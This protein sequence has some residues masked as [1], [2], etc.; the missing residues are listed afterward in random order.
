[1]AAANIALNVTAGGL[2]Q[3]IQNQV[4]NAQQT[5]NRRPLRLKLDPKGFTQPLGKISGD[6]SEFQKSLDASVARTFAFGAA[7]GVVN[8][9]SDAF[10]ALAQ[11]TIEVQKELKNINVLLGLSVSNLSTFSNELFGVA[12]NTAQTFKT[13]ATAATE[14]SRQGLSAEE[15]LKRVNDAM[16]LTRLSGL[17]AEQAVASLTAAV[18]GF[19][20]EAISTT[21]V[22]NRLA[23]V[24]AAFAVS[25][26][27]LADA[28]ARAGS[29]AQGAKV[30]FNELLAMVTSV[31][32]QTAR[33][34][35]VIGNA[36]K[37]IF[38][39]IQRSGVQDA[40]EE[41]GVATRNVD[42]SF[43]SGITVLK[44]YARTYDTLTDA[45]KAYTAE[46][47]AGVF[48]INNLKALVN[49]LNS[50]F[51][52]YDRALKVAN[53]STNEAN[54]RN[55]EL[56]KT[57]A[58]LIAQT[59][60]SMQQLGAALGNL[61]GAEIF[62]RLIKGVQAFADFFNKVL[63]PEEGNQFAIKFVKAIGSFI[64]GPGLIIIGGA[65]IKL[66]AFISK[67]AGAAV[68]SIFT[69]NT[70]TQRQQQ[71]Q[72]AILATI[73][74]EE[75]VYK[76]ILANAGNTA[77]QE[78]I[79]LDTLRQQTAQRAMQ[80]K[81][82][83]Q[84]ASSAAFKGVA[85]KGGTITPMGGRR[86]AGARAA[87][88]A[89]GHVPNFAVAAANT[90]EFL[91][92]NFAATQ[93]AK[94]IKAG[95]GGASPGARV[96]KVA[97]NPQKDAILNPD[98]VAAMG[99]PSGAQQIGAAG[100]FV[101]NFGRLRMQVPP[102]GRGGGGRQGAGFQQFKLA[103]TLNL[104]AF[105]GQSPIKFD[106]NQRPYI[107]QTRGGALDIFKRDN[108]RI[109]LEQ[110]SF[111]KDMYY[112]QGGSLT[113]ELKERIKNLYYSTSKMQT[114]GL[115]SRPMERNYERAQ[116]GR[117]AG[118]FVP[119]FAPRKKP[120][121]PITLVG[122]SAGAVV[123]PRAG[124]RG[125]LNM[126]IPGNTIL[127][128]KVKF[129]N[130]SALLK[131]P[132][133]GDGNLLAA[134][135]QTSSAKG[136]LKSYLA[137]TTKNFFKK[138]SG[139]KG[140]PEFNLSDNYPDAGKV[141][142][143]FLATGAKGYIFEEIIR[144]IQGDIKQVGAVKENAAFDINPRAL[145][146][147][148]LKDLFNLPSSTR[149]IELKSG[150]DIRKI[151]GKYKQD[152]IENINTP[153][154]S[155]DPLAVTLL[156]KGRRAQAAM[157]AQNRLDK[158]ALTKKGGPIMAPLAGRPLAKS[159]AAFAKM[160]KKGVPFGGGQFRINNQGRVQQRVGNTYVSP[161]GSP[162]A[163]KNKILMG[164]AAQGFLPNFFAGPVDRALKTERKMGAKRPEFRSSP[165]PHVADGATQDDFAAVQD[166]HP[167]GLEAAIAASAKMQG[168]AASGFIPNLAAG[169]LLK[170]GPTM[171]RNLKAW[172]RRRQRR[173]AA[174]GGDSG[175]GT[176]GMMFGL[177]Q[178]A[179]FAPE[180]GRTQA[181][182][183]GAGTG[184]MFGKRGMIA[185]AGL[186][187]LWKQMNKLGPAAQEAAAELEEMVSAQKGVSD[188][189]KN[190]IS[191]QGQLKDVIKKGDFSGA[192]KVTAQL[193]DALRVVP[194]EKFQKEILE[195]GGDLKKLTDIL[196]RVESSQLRERLGEGTLANLTALKAEQEGGFLG[197]GKKPEE[198]KKNW[199]RH[200]YRLGLVA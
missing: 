198:A 73:M 191:L 15:T 170:R 50:S 183:Q 6:M 139:G 185:G 162:D 180:G 101:P 163:L 28:L 24:D 38:T 90:D 94:A 127:G 71:L 194:L 22:I 29:T 79:I 128:Q 30:Q 138:A 151:G 91:V 56:N 86:G 57:F 123:T 117:L 114:V 33:G 125:A 137:D 134:A 108:P 172:W 155:V 84:M 20:T 25:S 187:A 171:G 188:G 39:R 157:A 70:E 36:F 80:Q 74:S 9:V 164:G 65:F 62:N 150:S 184:A 153:A 41:I 53:N 182:L 105:G 8:K 161:V 167:E 166:D 122:G 111:N 40:L 130:P 3:N 159:W 87:G 174:K 116:K 147:P 45:Q 21:E 89:G 34:G 189:L 132:V 16:I 10:R 156:Q 141:T 118:G 103:K 131:G 154:A 98:M 142:K 199:T 59:T 66:F 5:L 52:I 165:F 72:Q 97:F 195:A 64:A 158:A 46:Q 148:G 61:G 19:K 55:Q 75:S 69:I 27:D 178:A 85:V 186:G 120:Q 192:D 173:K 76:K 14:F 100:G 197:F 107:R 83:Q 88:L 110:A 51:S 190:Y 44:D 93:E 126:A 177:H 115:S 78:K 143:E 109:K 13:V 48:Q 23:N 32:Q 146:S 179:Q 17:G 42:G 140:V 47:L 11:A 37:S 136:Y 68:K 168:F 149:K 102:T 35:A 99:L 121:A 144:A 96:A 54:M 106:K 49:D 193:R 26:K 1:M 63:D 12:K 18:N 7:V 119:S 60:A 176:M 124:E 160:Q 169:A 135:M 82:L 58:A 133:K 81:F 181:A 196:A 129:A 4:N 2:Q 200:R 43:R 112:I 92:R 67:Q 152:L 95:T 31:Q 145:A 77:A 104:K 113:P 175:M